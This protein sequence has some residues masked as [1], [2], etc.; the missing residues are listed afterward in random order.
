MGVWTF[1][2][3]FSSFLAAVSGLQITKIFIP[4]VYVEKKTVRLTY[5]VFLSSLKNERQPL[6]GA[7]VLEVCSKT[8]NDVFHRVGPGSGLYQNCRV[9]AMHDEEYVRGFLLIYGF[10]NCSVPCSYISSTQQ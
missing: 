3:Y 6:Y 9:I 4:N 10:T 1:F 5:G 8:Y 7:C 2:L